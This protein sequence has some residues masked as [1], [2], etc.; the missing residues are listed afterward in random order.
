MAGAHKWICA[1]ATVAVIAG[2]TVPVS[3]QTPLQCAGSANNPLI[4]AE[5][6]TGLAGDIFVTCV[7]GVPAAPGALIPKVTITVFVTNTTITSKITDATL[8]PAFNEALLIVD[9]AGSVNSANS[10]LNCGS[11]TAPYGNVPFTCDTFSPNGDGTGDYDGQTNHPNVFQGRQVDNSFGQAIQFIGVPIDPP[12]PA[13]TP[14]SVPTRTLRITNLRVNAAAL[15]VYIGNPFS[16]TTINTTVSFNGTNFDG[17]PIVNVQ[18]GTIRPA[19]VVTGQLNAS[20]QNF[21]QCSASPSVVGLNNITLTEGFPTAFRVR[22]WRQIQDNGIP[23]VFPGGDW[24]WN[25]GS[26]INPIDLNQN[27]PNALY[28]TESGL[29]FPPGVSD[30][31][32]GNPPPGTGSF[33]SSPGGAAFQNPNGIEQA[34][35]ASQ[36]TRFAIRFSTIPA[37]SNPSVPLSVV[38]TAGTPAVPT[39]VMELVCGIDDAGAGGVPGSCTASA[40]AGFPGTPC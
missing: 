10:I 17:N 13:T 34:G 36:G 23:P 1:V 19:L 31:V 8:A 3:A 24:T 33:G 40:G 7:G 12:G 5:D 25:G 30:P 38:L 2:F 9:E 18:N 20:P 27:V 16:L 4:R 35:T 21:L 29:M 32:P 14:F 6:Y 11:A 39:G 37:G 15:N 28:S 26:S 22:N